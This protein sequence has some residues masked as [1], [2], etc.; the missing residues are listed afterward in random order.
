ML[1]LRK[2]TGEVFERKFAGD[3]IYIRKCSTSTAMSFQ[4]GSEDDDLKKIATLLT[5]CLCDKGGNSLGYTLDDIYAIPPDDAMEIAKL[6]LDVS[7]PK[8]NSTKKRNTGSR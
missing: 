2:Y 8:K 4:E 5:E 6:C 3:V 1:D 7:M